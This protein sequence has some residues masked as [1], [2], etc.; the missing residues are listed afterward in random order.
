[1]TRRFPGLT[2][3]AG[4]VFMVASA[5]G[6]VCASGAAHGAAAATHAAH[7]DAAHG[8]SASTAA[9]PAAHRVKSDVSAEEALKELITG[10]GRFVTGTPSHVNQDSARRQALA[11]GQKPHAIILSCS[12]SRVPPEILFDRGLGDV[13][14][15]RV[16]G[17]VLSDVATA[18]IEYAVEH[19]GAPLIVVMGHESCGAVKAALTLKAE[20]AG[21]FDLTSLVASIQ[22]NLAMPRADAHDDDAHADA[23][24]SGKDKEHDKGHDKGKSSKGSH[25]E[26]GDDA[27]HGGGE[28]DAHGDTHAADRATA[29]A[30]IAA[31][32][33]RLVEP[34]KANVDA[35]VAHLMKRSTIVRHAVDEGHIAIV[36]A[37]YRLSSGEVDFW[38]EPWSRKP[39]GGDTAVAKRS[40]K[41]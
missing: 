5:C 7:G 40:A 35:V 21:S 25:D 1:M 23:K 20:D 37:I 8:A 41:H 15:V 16:A 3:C 38:N 39:H 6:D 30:L 14:V 24:E 19:L 27:A 29:N 31:A 9:A 26:H 13:F 22:Q 2:V 17:N 28:T 18:S 34:V 33:P 12:D 32:D 11:G 36:P 10:N 4:A